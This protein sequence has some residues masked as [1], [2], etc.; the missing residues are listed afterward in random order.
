MVHLLDRVI[1]VGGAVEIPTP[2]IAQV[3]R[4]GSRQ[5]RLARLLGASDVV[6]VGLDAEMARAVGV[7]CGSVGVADVVDGHVALHARR[8]RP[9]RP[10]VGPGR[11]RAAGPDL[12]H[13]R[14]LGPRARPG[15]GWRATTSRAGSAVSGLCRGRFSL[16][17]LPPSS[18]VPRHMAERTEQ[19]RRLY[20]VRGP[21]SALGD[22]VPVRST[23]SPW[24]ARRWDQRPPRPR[25]AGPEPA[26]SVGRPWSP[27]RPC[28]CG[29]TG[30][31]VL[32]PLG[33][34]VRCTSARTAALR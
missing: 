20:G 7:L 17:S 21:T 34:A 33:Y 30:P 28:S 26:G 16:F 14:G 29:S 18:G 2:V 5:A 31:A 10:D 23:I 13:R 25:T 11:H 8:R 4:D 1:A 32:A 3:W 6:L 12:D 19:R 27:P 24:E 15:V 9:G 22:D